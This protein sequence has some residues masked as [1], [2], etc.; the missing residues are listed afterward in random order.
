[1]AETA[2]KELAILDDENGKALVEVNDEARSS[3]RVREA[4]RA[5]AEKQ[6]GISYGELPPAEEFQRRWTRMVSE[7]AMEFCRFDHPD[8][9]IEW[10]VFEL[11]EE[12]EPR[13]VT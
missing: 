3:A 13:R 1:M 10:W 9:D 2:E 12:S 4:F 6:W 5:A 7:D 11:P 8:A